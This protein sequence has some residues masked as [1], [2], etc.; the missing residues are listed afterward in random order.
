MASG[1]HGVER[2]KKG[3][4]GEAVWF[5][6][7]RGQMKRVRGSWIVAVVRQIGGRDAGRWSVGVRRDGLG[8]L[9][10]EETQIPGGAASLFASPG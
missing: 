6:P 5:V 3:E 1:E 9:K 8:R 7:A 10:E 2:T 4:D